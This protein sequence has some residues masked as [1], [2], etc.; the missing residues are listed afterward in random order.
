MEQNDKQAGLAGQA[1][2]ASLQQGLAGSRRCAVGLQP[3][4]SEGERAGATDRRL[5]EGGRS[6][7]RSSKFPL[8][9]TH[10]RRRKGAEKKHSAAVLP[11]TCRGLDASA[12]WPSPSWRPSSLCMS[13]PERNTSAVARSWRAADGRMR[14]SRQASRSQPERLRVFFNGR[15]TETRSRALARLSYISKAEAL[16]SARHGRPSQSARREPVSL[17]KTPSR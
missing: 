13:Q 5:V 8:Q 14:G 6:N 12:T 10:Q 3:R 16:K 15:K 1:G 7:L 9:S 2:R 11:C 17:A 4:R